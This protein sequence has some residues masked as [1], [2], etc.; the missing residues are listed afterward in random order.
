MSAET[1]PG[2]APP[3]GNW[4]VWV[5]FFG[6]CAPGS[7]GIGL[8]PL[9]TTAAMAARD[10][11][12]AQIGLAFSFD[13]FANAL[14]TIWISQRLARFSPQALGLVGATL[15]IAGNCLGMFGEDY[16]PL[17]LGFALRGAGIGCLINAQSAL[18]ARVAS[19]Q[20]L[21]GASMAIQMAMIIA[22]PVLSGRLIETHGQLGVFG[23]YAAAAA[24]ALPLIA[25]APGV[26]T[27]APPSTI[28]PS[29]AGLM[30]LIRS[31][32]V[33]AG[34]LAYLGLNAMWPFFAQVAGE[35]GLAPSQAG[36]LIAIVTV[37]A[38]IIGIGSAMLPDRLV[39]PVALAA[40]A[41]CAIGSG[42][43]PLAPSAPL[44]IAAFALMATSFT[45]MQNLFMTIGVRLDRTGGLNAGSGGVNSLIS[46]GTPALAGALIHATN[47]YASLAIFSLVALVGGVGMLRVA[48][49]G[50]E[51]APL[52]QA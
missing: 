17:V 3:Q 31:P 9:M 18:A 29:F 44:M 39:A 48:S 22:A 42:L 36:D 52:T 20:R 45:F 2:A 12:A 51:R 50:L 32:F 40:V 4:R 27:D 15:M 34:V 11:N 38:G 13:L 6:V 21:V 28:A 5:G 8:T 24:I 33:I 43:L 35:R 41:S 7:A 46:S 10:L 16:W 47:S 14:V 37:G 30:Q 19:P 25:F 49:R 26:R 1:G 23:V